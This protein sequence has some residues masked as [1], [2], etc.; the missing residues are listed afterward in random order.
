MKRLMGRST[1]QWSPAVR[2]YD[3]VERRRMFEAFMQLPIGTLAR[4]ARQYANARPAPRDQLTRCQVVLSEHDPVAPIDRMLGALRKL[5]FPD[6]QIHRLVA[7]GHVPHGQSTTH[8]EW[9][10]RNIIE[11]VAIIDHSLMSA[12]EGTVLPTQV[13][14]TLMSDGSSTQQPPSSEGST[15]PAD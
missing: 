12:R 7:E 9:T 1:F 14:S 6:H 4:G 11:L 13:A 5:D 15:Q 8:P 3:E 10:Q 2:A